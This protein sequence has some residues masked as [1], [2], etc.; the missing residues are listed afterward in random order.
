MNKVSATDGIRTDLIKKYRKAINE[1]NYE[2]K[3]MEIA[4]KMA[5]ELFNS[6]NTV[7]RTK[8]KV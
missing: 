3:S 1:K 2:V 4:A 5:D 6:K 7:I 8:L